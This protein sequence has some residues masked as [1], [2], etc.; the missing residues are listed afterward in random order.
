ME[1]KLFIDIIRKT[2]VTVSIEPLWN[3]NAKAGAEEGQEQSVS[4]EPLWNWNYQWQWLLVLVK[5]INRTFMEL[6][7]CKKVVDRIIRRYQSNLYGIEIPLKIQKHPCFP[8]VSIEP[9]WNWNHW[10][11]SVG[12][13]TK[14]VSIEPLWNWNSNH[15]IFEPGKH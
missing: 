2:A 6:K 4:I 15:V 13:K 5:R 8:T 9:L 12:G 10:G 11:T 7:C 1:L 14:K 3:W